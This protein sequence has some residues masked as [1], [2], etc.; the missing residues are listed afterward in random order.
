[1]NNRI[2]KSFR[3]QNLL[4][5]GPHLFIRS[6]SC[7]SWYPKKKYNGR[8]VGI[9]YIGFNINGL[10]SLNSLKRGIINSRSTESV[11]KSFYAREYFLSSLSSV[12]V[13]DPGC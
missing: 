12:P 13:F 4:L 3:Q 2:Q 11:R 6:D 1:M 7:N 10:D 8:E 9:E 5:T